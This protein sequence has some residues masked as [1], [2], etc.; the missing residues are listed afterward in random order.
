MIKNFSKLTSIAPCLLAI[1]IDVFGYGLVYPIMTAIFTNPSN[2]LVAGLG[3]EGMR[4]FFLGLAYLLY[5]LCMLFGSSF[6]GDLS[7]H[8]GRKRVIALCMGGIALSFLLMAIG[9][10]EASL[11]LL[12]AGRAL[13]GL[14]AGSQPIAQAAISDLSTPET[15]AL[16]MSLITFVICIGLVLGPLMGGVFSDPKVAHGFG[17]ETPFFIAGGISIIAVIWILLSFRETYIAKEKKP[18]SFFRPIQVFI[19]AFHHKKVR[20]LVIIFILMQVGFGLY[21][22]TILIQIKELYNYSSFLL[23]LL[24]VSWGFHLH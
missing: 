24:M 10:I 21:F 22:Q 13:S 3:S 2:P 16:N 1:V 23:E 4:D 11:T 7:D 19:D 9:V 8:F 5:P 18:L 20:F 6:M 15:K 14:M 17:F 12:L